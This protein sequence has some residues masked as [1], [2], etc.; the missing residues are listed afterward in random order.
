MNQIQE[1]TAL[2]VLGA[3][4]ETLDEK[5]AA[6]DDEKT[7]NDMRKKR[8]ERLKRLAAEKD[9]WIAAGHGSYDELGDPK[10]FFEASKR[11]QRMIVHFYR[12]GNESCKYLD[13]ILGDLSKSH[14]ETRF[15]RLDAEKHPYLTEKLHIWMLPTIVLVKN[16]QTEKSI[17]GFDELGGDPKKVTARLLESVLVRY[18][19]L[20]PRE[21]M[22]G[23][24]DG[25]DEDGRYGY[26]AG[27][28][29]VGIVGTS[30]YGDD[31]D[32]DDDNW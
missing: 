31:G 1:A 28:S 30:T 24:D 29:A 8:M 12:T 17:V 22:V 2:A 19:G 18:G 21:R 3:I 15:L 32:D 4:E 26:D 5:I 6:L 25:D 14:L 10:D 7:V 27:D 13:R 20:Q 23:E 9:S 11:S 16:Q